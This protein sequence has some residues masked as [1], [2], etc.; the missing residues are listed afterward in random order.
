[1]VTDSSFSAASAVLSAP[2]LSLAQSQEHHGRGIQEAGPRVLFLSPHCHMPSKKPLSLLDSPPVVSRCHS[3]VAI[4]GVGQCI[5]KSDFGLCVILSTYCETFHLQKVINCWYSPTTQG[6]SC[7]IIVSVI[8][9]NV[10]VSLVS[11]FSIE[12]YVEV[13]IASTRR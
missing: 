11:F 12:H 3:S 9:F 8:F 1:M 2:C 7:W 4:S 10:L 13:F 6:L 5:D